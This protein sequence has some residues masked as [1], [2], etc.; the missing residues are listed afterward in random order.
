MARDKEQQLREKMRKEVG[1]GGGARCDGHSR[2]VTVTGIEREG[3]GGGEVCVAEGWVNDAARD[4]HSRPVRGHRRRER[5]RRGQRAGDADGGAY[6]WS[7]LT[8]LRA[9][10][11]CVWPPQKEKKRTQKREKQRGC[12]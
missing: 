10:C 2:P 12:G 8:A 11:M 1:E 3:E 6:G 9:S 4:G 5:A 7:R